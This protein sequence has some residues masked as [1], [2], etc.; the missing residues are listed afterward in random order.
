MKTKILYIPAI[1]LDSCVEKIASVLYTLEA[2]ENIEADLDK[3]TIKLFLTA[4]VS[5][6][7]I[8]ALIKSTLSY[9]IKEIR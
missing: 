2:I 5:E 6:Y 4:D 3:K 7:E 9:E 8:K 1:K